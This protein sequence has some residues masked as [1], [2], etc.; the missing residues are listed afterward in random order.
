MKALKWILG[1]LAVIVAVVLIWAAV[2][3]K[4]YY[5]ESKIVIDQPAMMIFQS[6][7][8]FE[9]R[10]DW[11]P[12]LFSDPSAE[13]KIVPLP[14]NNFVGSEYYWD[15]EIIGEGHIRVDSVVFGKDVFSSLFFGESENPSKI[16]W[17]C[18][19]GAEGTEV[20][21][22]IASSSAYPLE[23][24]LFSFME[25]G[26]KE[27]LTKG[28]NN[29]KVIME[30]KATRL[31]YFKDLTLERQTAFHSVVVKGEATMGKKSEVM[32]NLFNALLSDIG[33]QSL[34][35][36][37]APFSFYDDSSANKEPFSFYAG[38]PV[39]KQ[40]Q[41]LNWSE[42]FTFEEQNV[43]AVT[44]IGPYDE[45]QLTYTFMIHYM[46]KNQV[47]FSGRIIEY[48]LNDLTMVSSDKLET[49]I[50]FLLRQ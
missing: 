47:P 18:I 11:D 9:N 26:M 39:N 36:I 50:V 21:W 16:T 22:T 31:S 28:L 4:T 14:E 15:G 29:L 48:Y 1:I 37:G 42:S 30:G 13:V 2:L 17:K 12:W 38:I 10:P 44:H 24:I 32:E 34:Q 41:G 27:R 35:I 45:L 25:K 7:V 46:G 40:A 3:P 6:I 33:D 8:S 5:S 19:P 43:V 20:A 23:R 49:K